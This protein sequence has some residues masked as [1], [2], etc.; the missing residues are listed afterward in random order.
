LRIGR[1]LT[2]IQAR[3]KLEQLCEL[4]CQEVLRIGKAEYNR[5]ISNEP[6][7]GVC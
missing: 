7:A 3:V 1:G 5:L 4:S 6:Y 2:A